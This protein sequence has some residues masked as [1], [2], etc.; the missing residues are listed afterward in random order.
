MQS[1]L[2]AGSAVFVLCSSILA[3]CGGSDDGP[4]PSPVPSPSPLVN[5]TTTK[6]TTTTHTTTTALICH[7]GNELDLCTSRCDYCDSAEQ[8]A[9]LGN[10]GCDQS[11]CIWVV[12]DNGT[13]GGVCQSPRDHQ[14]TTTTPSTG[15]EPH[16]NT[17]P[18]YMRGTYA[19]SEYECI[20]LG[21]I[22]CQ[23]QVCHYY[24]MQDGTE[25][26][27]SRH[28]TT[29]EGPCVPRTETDKCFTTCSTYCTQESDCLQLGAQGCGNA[30]CSWVD[31]K[32]QSSSFLALV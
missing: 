1:R 27:G 8:C 25:A 22:G 13:H 2:V 31:G 11:R 24:A 28:A 9:T 16:T 6:I 26:C 14:T 4:A 32:C 10:I 15:C 29:T 12:P 5:A 21:P 20:A 18:C 23:G 7:P 30:A 19:H 3:G 17:D